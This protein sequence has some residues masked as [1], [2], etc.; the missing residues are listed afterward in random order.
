MTD[1][2]GEFSFED[3]TVGIYRVRE[4]YRSLWKPLGIDLGLPVQTVSQIDSLTIQVVLDTASRNSFAN[5]FVNY[6]SLDPI[7]FIGNV[8]NNYLNPL[9]WDS[10]R[11]PL[12][13]DSIII[14]PGK[15]VIFQEITSKNANENI[16]AL[17]T[18]EL[19]GLNVQ[20]E[21][22]VLSDRGIAIGIGDLQVNGTLTIATESKP[23][24]TLGGD[25]N[26]SGG[27]KSV[28]GSFSPGKSTFIFESGREQHVS[29]SSFYN[30]EVGITNRLITDGDIFVSD[31]MAVEDTV[32]ALGDTIF[33]QNSSP[34]GLKFDSDEG[35]IKRG[36]IVRNIGTSNQKYVFQNNETDIEFI[37]GK[38]GTIPK[39]VA[40]TTYPD[41]YA[42]NAN[43]EGIVSRYYD[44]ESNGGSNFNATLKLQYD[45]SELPDGVEPEDVR[46]IKSEDGINFVNV[47]GISDPLNYTVTLSGVN[48][49]SRW[50]M[51]QTGHKVGDTTKFTTLPQESLAT[52]AVKLKK[53]KGKPT[54][55]PN[56]GN[57]RD[58]AFKLQ[59]VKPGMILGVPIIDKLLLKTRGYLTISK[60]KSLLKFMPQSGA[61]QPFSSDMV[62]GK[63]F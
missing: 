24:I 14:P 60:G 21:L 48:E 51:G 12:A 22:T 3:L 42:P 8:D 39:S 52:V 56:S 26:I 1:S 63:P 23:I 46:F 35:S 55:Q 6:K 49:F 50:V 31:T 7:K 44:I 28:S 33:I 15:I 11:L 20:G 13:S 58:E 47:G 54:P 29:S 61:A 9:N 2:A 17:P 53:K 62:K 4:E 43:F 5:N 38:T 30:L 25:F 19:G 27:G 18:I 34:A 16:F 40:M 32:D 59:I 45:P 37:P 10:L 41:S 57:V 36:T